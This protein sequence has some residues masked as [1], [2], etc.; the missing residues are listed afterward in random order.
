MA[1]MFLKDFIGKIPWVHFDIAGTAYLSKALR[2]N[3]KNASGVGIRLM[4]E[5]LST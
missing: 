4:L 5:F 3:P 2:Y 1:G